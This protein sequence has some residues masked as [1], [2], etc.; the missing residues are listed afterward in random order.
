MTQ[1]TADRAE[2]ARKILFRSE[3]ST[4]VRAPLDSATGK[5]MTACTHA[6][7]PG[8][9]LARS[10]PQLIVLLY[11]SLRF[12]YPDTAMFLYIAREGADPLLNRKWSERLLTRWRGL[13]KPGLFIATPEDRKFLRGAV[14]EI[15]LISLYRE[16][17]SRGISGGC[18]RELYRLS[19]PEG[20][21]FGEDVAELAESMGAILCGGDHATEGA[22]EL[23]SEELA[24]VPFL[25]S[26]IVLRNSLLRRGFEAVHIL[27]LVYGMGKS[28]AHLAH[29]HEGEHDH[30]KPPA[31]PAKGAGPEE[32]S[33]REDL[34]SPEAQRRNLQELHDT[35]LS[36]FWNE[37]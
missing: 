23:S 32:S 29:T 21:P 34:F 3:E 27:E 13:G 35:L 10:E 1:N 24:K 31:V 8:M 2:S 26:S 9:A 22:P 15:P 4:L 30:H 16:L 18:N 33:A 19:E 7:F 5:D 11:D 28:N 20:S 17:L 37:A 36:L 14:P 12:Q 6:L 25:T